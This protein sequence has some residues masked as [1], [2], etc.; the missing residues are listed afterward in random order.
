MP[1]EDPKI[2]INLLKKDNTNLTRQL[3]ACYKNVKSLT[4]QL[5]YL[6]DSMKGMEE[7]LE[8]F[9]VSKLNK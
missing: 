2:Q 7:Q 9:S 3:Y 4:S 8:L 5:E 6:K 1:E